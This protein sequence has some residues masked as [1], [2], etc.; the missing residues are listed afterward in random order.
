[1][2][3]A[4]TSCHYTV[5]YLNVTTH[6]TTFSCPAVSGI[7][8]HDSGTKFIGAGRLDCRII[9]L[10]CI[11]LCRTGLGVDRNKSIL[12]VTH[13]PSDWHSS[14]KHYVIGIAHVRTHV[15]ISWRTLW[16]YAPVRTLSTAWGIYCSTSTSSRSSTSVQMNCSF[17]I[18]KKLMEKQTCKWIWKNILEVIV[19]IR[20]Q[21]QI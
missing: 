12:A 19:K 4:F 3:S 5:N 15:R 10:Y 7:Q 20:I 11:V 2:K 16:L 18:L 14:V 6:F 1:M 8:Q 21:I 9:I 13:C 17:L